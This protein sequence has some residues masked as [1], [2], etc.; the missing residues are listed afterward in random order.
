MSSENITKD[1]AHEELGTWM[2]FLCDMCCILYF[3]V[4]IGRVRVA[5]ITKEYF[6]NLSIY[7]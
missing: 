6:L 7:I 2:H 3:L 1:E 4:E 5:I